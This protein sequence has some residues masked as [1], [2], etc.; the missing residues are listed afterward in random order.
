MSIRT[1]AFVACAALGLTACGGRAAQDRTAPIRALLSADALML[2]SF[3]TNGDLSVSRDE[4][5]A[6]FAREFARADADN[7]GALSPIEFSNWSSLVLGGSQIGPY[8]LD[9]DRNV[10]NVIT[11]EEYDTE[12]RARFSQYDADENGALSRTEFVRLVG[13]AR[14]PTQRRQTAPTIGGAGG[15]GE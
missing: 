9:F 2:V 14:P 3:D 7:N 12:L 10:D 4:A 8:R 1:L 5:E 15:P 13:Q 11:R 6:G